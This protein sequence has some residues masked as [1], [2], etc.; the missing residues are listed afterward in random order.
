[1]FFAQELQ[2]TAG[3]RLDVGC[4][5]V[6]LVEGFAKKVLMQF[7]ERWQLEFTAPTTRNLTQLG[8]VFSTGIEHRQG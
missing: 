8:A 5:V 6:G 7:G 1:M 2:K 3:R 4:G